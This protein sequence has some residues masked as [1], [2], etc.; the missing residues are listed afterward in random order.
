MDFSS[1]GKIPVSMLTSS[2]IQAGQ[3]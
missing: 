3:S 2:A 1:G